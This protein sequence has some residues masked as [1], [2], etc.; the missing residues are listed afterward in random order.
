MAEPGLI[1]WTSPLGH[2]YPSRLPPIMTPMPRPEPRNWPHV[3]G[4][5]LADDDAP[6]MTTEPRPE[7]DPASDADPDDPEVG[8]GSASC[9]EGGNSIGGGTAP[10]LRDI[11]PF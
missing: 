11:P 2:D 7:P 8:G 5:P 9:G 4:G 6:I 10:L 1:I 3:P